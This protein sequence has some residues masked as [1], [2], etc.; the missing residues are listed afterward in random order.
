MKLNKRWLGVLASAS[1]GLSGVALAAEN[2]TMKNDTTMENSANAGKTVK[3]QITQVL[4]SD[5][6]LLLSDQAAPLVVDQHAKVTIDG[7]K[8]SFSDLKPGDDVRAA[9]DETGAKIVEITAT[10][11]EKNE[12]K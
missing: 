8:K 2:D 10:S 7:E 6:E 11:A 12:A 5:H 9:Y 1:L 4:K 3:G